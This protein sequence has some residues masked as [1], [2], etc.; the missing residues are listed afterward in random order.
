M[1]ALAAAHSRLVQQQQQASVWPTGR[2]GH[3]AGYRR[4]PGGEAAGHAP[5]AATAHTAQ[6]DS[7]ARAGGRSAMAGA[8]RRARIGIPRPTRHIPKCNTGWS[9]RDQALYCILG[10]SSKIDR[11]LHMEHMLIKILKAC[12]VH[13]PNGYYSTPCTHCGH[14]ARTSNEHGTYHIPHT[15]PCGLATMARQASVGGCAWLSGSSS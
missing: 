8:Q 6:Q 3:M 9:L 14:T 15:S 10:G 5:A 12:C 1:P 13:L 7:T 2:A 4:P 11:V